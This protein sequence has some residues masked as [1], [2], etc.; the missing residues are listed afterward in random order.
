MVDRD[1]P[2]AR[3]RLLAGVQR[4]RAKPVTVAFPASASAPVPLD[5][6]V[7]PGS[8]P[9]IWNVPYPRNAFFTGRDEI[10]T[11]LRTQLQAV[12]ATSLSQTQAITGLGRLG[13]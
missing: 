9:P 7:F 6:P 4:E 1:E 5:R 13:H 10:L 3:E 2:L 11:R 12:Q 8:L